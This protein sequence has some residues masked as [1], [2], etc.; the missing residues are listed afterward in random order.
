MPQYGSGLFVS[1]AH[2]IRGLFGGTTVTA[3]VVMTVINSL[4]IWALIALAALSLILLERK[5]AG[6]MQLR[7]GPNRLGPRGWFQTVADAMKLLGKEDI[8]PAAADKWVFGLAPMFVIGLSVMVMAVIPYGKGMVP[9]D[10]NVGIFYLLAVSA[11]TT[12]PFFMAGWGSNNKF[13]LLGGMRAVAQMI[14][15][16][17]PLVFSLLGV[18]MIT[19][20][21]KMSAIVNAQSHVWFI[22]LQPLGFVV[23]TIAATAETNRAPF[24]LVEGESELTAGAFTEY[25]GMRWALFFLGEYANLFI[26][27]AVAATVFLGGWQ[28]PFLPGWIWFAIKV[29][30]MVFLFLW[31]RWTFPRLRV[32]QLMHFGWK[33]LL[34][35]SVANI[36]LTGVGI[37]I[38]Q[39]IYPAIGG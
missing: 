1:I 22:L 15:Y 21:F 2:L 37:Y 39:L 8:F 14:S 5:V 30:F 4:I 11:L 28:G 19:Q 3:D 20:T 36:L 31:F 16:E 35:L 26:V 13:A 27:S 10:L 34:P 23:Y 33:V 24:D 38:Y 17:I 6:W 25:T 32:D 18:V 7:T 29:L 9:V 12:I